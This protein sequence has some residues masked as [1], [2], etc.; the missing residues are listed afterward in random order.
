MVLEL[1][2]RGVVVALLFEED[3][4][5]PFQCVRQSTE[6][7]LQLITII[8]ITVQEHRD[9]QICF[10]YF[11]WH[12]NRRRRKGDA[13][14]EKAKS[15]PKQNL[16]CQG[17]KTARIVVEIFADESSELLILRRKQSQE[18]QPQLSIIIRTS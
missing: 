16:L 14:E 6:Y 11:S 15:E 7:Q 10:Q 8:H 13:D 4:Q 18:E 3:R 17:K 1:S 9:F 12:E 2:L 5:A